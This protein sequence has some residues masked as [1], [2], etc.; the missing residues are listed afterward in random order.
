MPYVFKIYISIASFKI[1]K[2]NLIRKI[3]IFQKDG[4]E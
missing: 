3:E 2:R 1:Q 4:N